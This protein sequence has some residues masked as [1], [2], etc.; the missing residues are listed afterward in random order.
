M[1]KLAPQEARFK[2]VVTVRN[3]K[4]ASRTRLMWNTRRL[5]CA[6]KDLEELHVFHRQTIIYLS[7]GERG[8]Q[9]KLERDTA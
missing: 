2:N 9:E 1:L 6:C 7:L 3:G 8:K 5:I 4:T